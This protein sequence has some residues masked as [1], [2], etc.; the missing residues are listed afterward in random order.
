MSSPRIAS[1]SIVHY[2][3]SYLSYALRSVRPITDHNFIFFTPH[4]SHGHR[5][6][7]PPIESRDEVMS[8]IPVDMWDKITWYDTDTFWHEGGQRDYALSIASQ[9]YDLV[10]NLDYDEIWS[11]EALEAII[12]HVWKSNNARNHLLNFYG[13]F[14]RSFSWICKD[15]GWP[16]RII[17]TRHKSGL[18]YIPKELGPVWHFGY[19]I[20]DKV[21][22]YKL[23]IH[24]HHDEL[25]PEWLEE[26]WNV[27]PPVEDC[28]PTNGRKEDGTGWWNPEPFDKYLLPEF[29]YSHPYFNLDKIE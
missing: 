6:D 23:Q 22:Q 19:A 25:R 4:P 17:D 12:N 26:K 28:H 9:D 10:I 11:E 3:K 24:G 8:S 29:M 5:T 15:E 13:H 14:W 27:W 1:Y 18:A 20:S 7:L 2:G 21:M 16:V